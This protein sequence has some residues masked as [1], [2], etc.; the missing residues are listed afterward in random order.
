MKEVE[1]TLK[2]IVVILIVIAGLLFINTTVL[3]F[4]GGTS[5]NSTSEEETY[6]VSM[7]NKID[8]TEFLKVIKNSKTQV[9]YLGRPSCD[10]CVQ[11]LPTLQEAQTKLK[12]TTNYVDISDKTVSESSGYTEMVEKI[13]ALTDKFNKDHNLTG[14]NAYKYLYG[15][16]PLIVLAKDGK[17]VDVWLG[18]AD[19]D[20]FT[21]WLNDN[22]VK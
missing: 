14:D 12:Y 19:Y 21:E 15:I 10:Y 4:R 9:I 20:T 3:L 6:D 16:T 7:F 13:D 1:K 11:F 17:I 8:G 18:A 2:N 5:T 22:G